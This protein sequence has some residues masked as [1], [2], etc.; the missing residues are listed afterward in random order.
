MTKRSSNQQ[1]HWAYAPLTGESHLIPQAEAREEGAVG[2]K[3]MPEYSV[4]L[5][6]WGRW[7]H[8]ELS[9]SLLDRL[10]RWQSEF[11]STFRWDSGWRSAA[12]RQ[13]WSEEARS[14]EA[15]LRDEVGNRAEVTVDLWPLKEV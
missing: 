4:D 6:L 10:R 1:G 12:D 14:L 11:D 7:E 15:D 2:V 13:R 8:L 3:L 9:E 5:P